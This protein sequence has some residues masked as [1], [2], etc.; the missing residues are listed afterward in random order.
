MLSRGGLDYERR[1]HAAGARKQAIDLQDMPEVRDQ[2]R[3]YNYVHRLQLQH[4]LAD[5]F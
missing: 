3:F 4:Q 2:S 1:M 5:H